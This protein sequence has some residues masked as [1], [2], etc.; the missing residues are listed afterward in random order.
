MLLYHC[1]SYI[2][3]MCHQS[4][5]RRLSF[6]PVFRLSFSFLISM[7]VGLPTLKA[8]S[9]ADFDVLKNNNSVEIIL[10]T[11][12]GSGSIRG[13]FSQIYGKLD[14]PFSNPKSTSGQFLLDARTL[15]F[16]YEKVNR[17]V[18]RE[19]WLDTNTFPKIIYKINKLTKPE[20]RG[21]KLY[22]DAEG[23]LK[24]HNTTSSL[25]L[26]LSLVYL[27]SER[28][29]YDGTKGDVLFIKG[30]KSLNLNNLGIKNGKMIDATFEEIRIKF[31]IV[32]GSKQVRPFL[33]S[34]IFNK[35]NRD[36]GNP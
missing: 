20:W 14:F 24:I 31:Q 32:L 21:S 18:H 5:I 16:G 29:K 36:S 3:E 19:E 10:K 12:F 27:R 23:Q 35:N 34:Q 26:P 22:A 25:Q 1:H 17:D 33:P 13:R 2:H 15:R 7:L 11:N 4:D 28:I 8:S 6:I 30:E 9:S